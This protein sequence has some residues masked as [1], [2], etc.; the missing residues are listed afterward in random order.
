MTDEKPRKKRKSR[1]RVP[2]LTPAERSA[3]NAANARKDGRYNADRRL[4]Q[5][6]VEAL[7]AYYWWEN[8]KSRRESDPPHRGIEA[9]VCPEWRS[10]AVAMTDYVIEHHGHRVSRNQKLRKLDDL[11]WWAPGNTSGYEYVAPKP[12]RRT[13]RAARL[14]G[15][16]DPDCLCNPG[17]QASCARSLQPCDWAAANRDD[18]PWEQPPD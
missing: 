10:D 12:R 7:L 9:E 16:V 2:P 14:L 6:L 13:R 8:S 11:V 17:Q 18:A 5:E 3:I 1:A 4:T 15:Q